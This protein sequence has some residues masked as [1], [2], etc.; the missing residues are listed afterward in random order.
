[1]PNFNPFSSDNEDTSFEQGLPVNQ[2]AKNVAKTVSSQVQAQAKAAQKALMDQLYGPSDSS[3]QDQGTDEAN[4][5]HVD[6]TNTANR[7]TVAHAANKGSNTNQN[8]TPDEQAKLEKIRRELF[9][10]NYSG[11]FG[12]EQQI[13][14]ARKEREQREQQLKQQDEEEQQR[15]EAEKKQ[16]E[17]EGGALLPAGKKTG[18]MFGKKQQQPIA[19][20][21][22]KTKTEVNRGASG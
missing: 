12:V 4:P 16:M 7:M 15:K 20:T 14:K 18:S 10:K 22:A 8:Q 1:M 2:T 19:L 11:Q 3:G 13:E 9:A 5:Q 21:Q 17:E 6:L